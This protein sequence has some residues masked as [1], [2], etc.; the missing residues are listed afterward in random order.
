V[1][2]HER[3]VDAASAAGLAGRL[4]PPSG[5]EH[6]LVQPFAGVAERCIVALTFTGAEPVERDGEELHAGE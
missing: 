2:P 1:Q 6:P 5:D 4:V 3:V